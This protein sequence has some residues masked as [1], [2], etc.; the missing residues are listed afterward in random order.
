M[1]GF[2]LTGQY[3]HHEVPLH[4]LEMIVITSSTGTCIENGLHKYATLLEMK[5]EV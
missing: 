2:G 4:K 3:K 5:K 1:I